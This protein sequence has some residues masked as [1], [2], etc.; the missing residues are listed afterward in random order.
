MKRL[1]VVADYLN[2][3]LSTI[4]II[5]L[6]LVVF[7]SFGVFNP[8]TYVISRCELPMGFVC[9]SFSLSSNGLLDITIEN[10]MQDPINI[11]ALGCSSKALSNMQSIGPVYLPRGASYTFTTYCA[12][13]QGMQAGSVYTGYIS[14]NYTDEASLISEGTFGKIIAK[15][16]N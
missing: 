11:T 8:S 4:A 5:S 12:G 7:Y 10:T 2:A 13:A 3:Y 1:Q 16:A 14:I 6:M 15:F 9:K